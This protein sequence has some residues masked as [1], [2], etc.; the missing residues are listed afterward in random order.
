METKFEMI[1]K[2]ILVIIMV[3]GIVCYFLLPKTRLAKK[4]KMNEKLF[5]FTN[6]V[7]VICGI[8]GLVTTFIVPQLIVE[9]H[10][11]EL[12]VTP[13]ALIYLYWLIIIK[14][15]KTSGILDEKQNSDMEKAGAITM[16]FSIPMM[17]I[18][19]WLYTNKIFNGPIWFP[20]YFFVIIVLFSGSTLFLF[21]KA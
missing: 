1:I 16:A 2:L 7:S 8:V 12:I 5:I 9:F 20:Y 21:K 4:F 3:L 19:F 10:L 13:F 18:M 11:W 15:R 17:V 14:I 6:I